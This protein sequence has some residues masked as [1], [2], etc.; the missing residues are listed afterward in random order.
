MSKKKV[1]EQEKKVKAK[2]KKSKGFGFSKNRSRFL[3]GF[4]DCFGSL[5]LLVVL[6]LIYTF[7]DVFYIGFIELL[8][9]LVFL[10]LS[11]KTFRKI[12]K[13][14]K[15]K[16]FVLGLNFTILGLYLASSLWFLLFPLELILNPIKEDYVIVK[17]SS[18]QSDL[19]PNEYSPNR[20]LVEII[21]EDFEKYLFYS[22]GKGSWLLD[23]DL[24]GS[25]LLLNFKSTRKGNVVFDFKK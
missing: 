9:G 17:S 8:I 20:Q 6:W 5:M 13:F 3:N 15:Q 23:N 11:F 4:L 21:S 12:K 16:N 18:L 22:E 1:N 7:H 19:I 24:I 10:F 14:Y 2:P 25:S